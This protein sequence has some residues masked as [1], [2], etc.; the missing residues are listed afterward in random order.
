MKMFNFKCFSFQ[1]YVAK[2]S[3]FG[4]AKDGP[5]GD[6]THISTRVMGTEGY[7][8]P[9]YIQTGNKSMNIVNYKLNYHPPTH[10]NV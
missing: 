2:L 7:A 8:A 5:E 6:D 1:D 4:L 3:D 10:L 9:E